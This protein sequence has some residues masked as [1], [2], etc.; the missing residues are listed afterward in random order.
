LLSIEKSADIKSTN[1]A[2]I[3]IDDGDDF[4]DLVSAKVY[5]AGARSPS[6]Q[7]IP[8]PI[9]IQVSSPRSQLYNLRRKNK[10]WICLI[11]KKNFASSRRRFY[12]LKKVR[13]PK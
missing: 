4:C 5:V 12:N 10:R 13:I 11:M 1:G 8:L 6:N 7:G 9:T 2:D 3:F